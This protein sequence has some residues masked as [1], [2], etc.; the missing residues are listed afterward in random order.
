MALIVLPEGQQR[1]GSVGGATWSRNRFGAYLRA[2]SVPV[3]PNT[4]RMVAVRNA[5]R[6]L[7]V[8][9]ENTL[10]QTQRNAWEAYA[11]NVVWQNHLGQSIFLT[12]LNHYVRSNVP[13]IQA[14]MAQ[15]D[16]SPGIFNLGDAEGSLACTASEATQQASVSFDN[17]KPWATE[18]GAAEIFYG[19]IP[20]NASI[21]FFG[22]PWRL[23]GPALGDSMGAPASPAVINWPWPFV[24]GNRL[25]IR[26]RI[27]RA[28]AR[29]SEF[30]RV[31][32]LAAA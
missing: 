19:G 12:G 21:K 10:T 14:G 17:T 9:W 29:L 26:S 31:N 25:W 16:V 23:I 22:G 20:K 18:D 3:N 8:A 27:T 32:F 5:V 6:S 4:D 15:V 11:A 13:R 30:A 1:S 2:R 7:T 24:E 28:D